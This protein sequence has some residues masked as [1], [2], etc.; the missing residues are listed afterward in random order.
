MRYDIRKDIDTLNGK[1]KDLLGQSTKLAG[2]PGKEKKVGD[3]EAQAAEHQQ[4]AAQLKELH[5][6]VTRTLA[7]EFDRYNANKNR[8]VL[9]VLQQHAF[10]FTEFTQ[11][12]HEMWG[13]IASNVVARVNTVTSEA[14]TLSAISALPPPPLLHDSPVAGRPPPLETNGNKASPSEPSAPPKEYGSNYAEAAPPGSPKEAA[15]SS[16][17][18]LSASGG[19]GANPFSAAPL[20]PSGQAETGGA[21]G[22]NPFAQPAS[23]GGFY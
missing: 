7:W 6:Q 23:V 19:A 18:R 22:A 16:P 11:K 10:G 8:D 14:Q 15:P 17:L 21:S 20:A 5:D 4:R 3:L 13:T 1:I 9:A 2:R 12:E